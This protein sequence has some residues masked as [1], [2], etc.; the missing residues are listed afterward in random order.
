MLNTQWRKSS[1]SG[2]NGACVEARLSVT[3]VEVR[4]SKD[5]SG[6]TLHATTGEWRELLA[7]SRHGSR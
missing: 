2:P 3:G 1:K 6:P 7:I 5:V 4:D